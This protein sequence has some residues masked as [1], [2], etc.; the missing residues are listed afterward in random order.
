MP[1]PTTAP[2]SASSAIVAGAV[3]GHHV[4]RIDGYSH[5]KNTVR[6]GQHVRS[7]MFRAAGRSWIVYYY[8]NG[9]T[10]E[11]ADFISLYAELQ[12]GVLT[13]AQ[14]TRLLRRGVQHVGGERFIRRDQL[15]QSEYVR[16]DRLA[17]R[18]DVAVMDK[19]RTTEEIAGGGGG[20]VPPSE[21]SRQFADLLASGDGADVEF[22]V[23]GETVAAHRAV[24]AA[25]SRVFRAELFGPMKEG[26][27]ANGTIQVDDMDA[28]VF[29]SLLHFVYTDSL[30]PEMGTPREGA[31][32][33]Q[34]L[35]VAADRLKLICE[36]R[37]CEHIGVATAATTLELAERHH[38]HG[39]KR[40]CMEFLSSPTNLKAVME[41]DGFEQLSC[42]AVLKELM[43][44]ALAL[45]RFIYT[46]APPELDEEDDDFSMAWL[47]VAADRYNV[48]RLKMICENE[49][50]KRID[51]NNFEATLALAEQHHCSCPWFNLSFSAFV[52]EGA[53][54][55]KFRKF[56]KF[57]SHPRSDAAP[58]TSG[59]VGSNAGA[60]MELGIHYSGM[61]KQE[62][63][64]TTE[65][66]KNPFVDMSPT[67]PMTMTADE[68]TTASAIVAG[69]ATGHHVLR[70]DGYSRTKNVVPNG[71]F[72]TSRSFRAAG[73]SWHVFYYPNGFDDESIEYI[74]LYLLLEDA[75]TATTATTTT[76]QFTVTL[77][78]KDGRQVPSQKA[79]SGVFT[80]S[81]EIQKY[82][83]TQFISRDEL[84]QSEHLDGDRFALRFDIT[85]VGKFRAEEIAGPVG[86]P[87]V[88]VPPSD[89]RRHFGDLLASGDGAD[90][91][92]RV[93]GAG[94]EEETVAAHRVV[95]AA[96][97]PVFKAELLAGVP[98]KDGGGAVIQIDDMDAEV[99]R[100]LLHYMYTDSLPPEKGTTREE[101]AM[102]QNMIVAADRYS[103]ETLKLMCEDRLRKH[104]GASSVATMLTFADRHHCH[105]LR[106]ACTEF[107]SSPTNLKA[108]MATDG[109]GQ[110]SC[111]TC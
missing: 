19:L 59:K 43:A 23:G 13:T 26:V 76:V 29:R 28:E 108:A 10:A 98:A 39:L 83:F 50:C 107:L 111:P 20:A 66:Y 103:M 7:C 75:A 15:E 27:A 56:R 85:V 58:M 77:L 62:E 44:K 102:A 6:N 14:F 101:A 72:I 25:R 42:P 5:T 40:A 64:G 55:P 37:L 97:S 57:R 87:Y 110:L 34:H 24:L 89:M 88:A 80:Y 96:R 33:A 63:D 104:I 90:V 71:Q 36:E 67:M 1:P 61:R 49:L 41:T 73:H 45:L 68:P 30:P 11:S 47:L 94:G 86:A 78:D 82:G 21:M 106:A 84:E 91:E 46:D 31:A 69:V 32:M 35:I 93:R 16:D 79:N 12:D 105:G 51:G 18:F 38:C 52:S 17:I 60:R 2:L 95:L 81:S 48:E 74:S 3:N 109:F 9:Y 4:L 70:I 100:S 22:R 65:E 92:F 53:D 8:P 54:I 99:F